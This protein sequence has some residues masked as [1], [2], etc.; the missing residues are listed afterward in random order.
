MSTYNVLNIGFLTRKT[1]KT[2]RI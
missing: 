2:Y 1:V